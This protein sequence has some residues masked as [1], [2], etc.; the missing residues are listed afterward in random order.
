MAIEIKLLSA[1]AVKPGLV[2]VIEAFQHESGY[3]VDVTFATAPEI[4]KRIGG[5]EKP[6]VV[7]APP[8]LLDDLLKSGKNTAAERATVGRIGVGV[9]VHNDA[10]IPTIA[11]VNDFKQ[12]LLSAK[13]VVYNQASSGIYLEALFDRLGISAQL[14]DKTTRYADFAAVRDHIV[15]GTDREIGLGATTVIIESQSKGLKFLG[16]LPVEIQNY[17]TYAA[18]VTE[19]SPVTHAALALVRYF[20]TLAAKTIFASAGIE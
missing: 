5:G 7:L 20:T 11:T 1:G 19:G 18:T 6:D 2:K 4:R 3:K 12:S 16:P 14:K 8:A 15:K 10:S 9:M 17:T 13:S